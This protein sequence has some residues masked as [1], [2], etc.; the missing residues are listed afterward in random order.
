MT[1]VAIHAVG[2]LPGAGARRRPP[3]IS[4]ST[5]KSDSGSSAA[6]GSPSTPESIRSVEDHGCVIAGQCAKT[7]AQVLHACMC[8][9][10][11]I[12]L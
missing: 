5:T 12:L 6:S 10:T 9:F 7:Y 4:F 1:H 8:V 3:A 11:V 2:S